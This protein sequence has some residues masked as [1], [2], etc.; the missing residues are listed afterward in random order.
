MNIKKVTSIAIALGIITT[1]GYFFYQKIYNQPF[2][3]K[4]KSIA[5]LIK[6]NNFNKAETF[7]A[8]VDLK[9]MTTIAPKERAEFLLYQSTVE[10]HNFVRSPQAKDIKGVTTLNK[11]KNQLKFARIFLIPDLTPKFIEL[12][13]QFKEQETQITKLEQELASLNTQQNMHFQNMFNSMHQ[14]SQRK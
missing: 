10:L 2:S 5:T 1:S 9:K 7:I 12:D 8:K 14:S 3:E 11:I 13:V 6:E 4:L